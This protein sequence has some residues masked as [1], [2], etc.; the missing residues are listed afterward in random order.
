MVS[1]IFCCCF[2]TA[3]QNFEKLLI[4]LTVDSQQKIVNSSKIKDKLTEIFQ[5]FSKNIADR[6]PLKPLLMV[7][8]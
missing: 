5:V 2:W 1:L 6:L 7:L 4:D 8:D 3:H